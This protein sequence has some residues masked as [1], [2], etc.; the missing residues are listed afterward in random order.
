MNKR[1]T[2]NQFQ[3]DLETTCSELVLI[4]ENLNFLIKALKFQQNIKDLELKQI[5]EIS[6]K[7]VE[8]DESQIF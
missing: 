8:L 2:N 7:V 3:K 1:T 6:N 4:K 5:F